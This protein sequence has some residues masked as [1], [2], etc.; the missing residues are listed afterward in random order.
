L[1]HVNNKFKNKA[2][3]FNLAALLN[4]D[5]KVQE[6]DAR[7]DEQGTEAGYKKINEKGNYQ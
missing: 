4:S 7:D 2:A 6:C 1:F 5:T 3:T